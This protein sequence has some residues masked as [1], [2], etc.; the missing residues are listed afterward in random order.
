MLACKPTASTDASAQTCMGLTACVGA[1]LARKFYDMRRTFNHAGLTIRSQIRYT[2]YFE[3][4]LRRLVTQPQTVTITQSTAPAIEIH[5]VRLNTI[6][7]FDLDGGCDPIVRVL[8][9]AEDDHQPIVVFGTDTIGVKHVSPSSKVF[10]LSL[11]AVRVAGDFALHLFDRDLLREEKMGTLWLHSLFL[12]APLLD[13]VCGVYR[14]LS[15]EECERESLPQNTSSLTFSKAH[16][17]GAA[18]D[19]RDAKFDPDFHLEIFFTSPPNLRGCGPNLSQER[20]SSAQD[21]AGAMLLERARDKYQRAV[22]QAP[23]SAAVLSFEEWVVKHWTGSDFGEYGHGMRLNRQ[24]SLVSVQSS[25]TK[26]SRKK[27]ILTKTMSTR[28]TASRTT[29]NGFFSSF[30]SRATREHHSPSGLRTRPESSPIGRY[31]AASSSTRKLSSHTSNEAAGPRPAVA[32]RASHPRVRTDILPRASSPGLRSESDLWSIDDADNDHA[33]AA[34]NTSNM[35]DNMDNANAKDNRNNNNMDKNNNNKGYDME[36]PKSAAPHEPTRQRGYSN[37]DDDDDDEDVSQE[38]RAREGRSRGR[39]VEATEEDEEEEDGWESGPSSEEDGPHWHKPLKPGPDRG[40]SGPDLGQRPDRDPRAGTDLGV[41][42]ARSYASS[43]DPWLLGQD[44]H[45]TLS[46]NVSSAPPEPRPDE[47]FRRALE[48]DLA[49][50]LGISISCVSCDK[51]ARSQAGYLEAAIAFFDDSLPHP[52]PD[53][54]YHHTSP[55]LRIGAMV[56]G[57]VEQACDPQSVLR[58][59][60]TSRYVETVQLSDT[61]T[62][63]LFE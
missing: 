41:Q 37:D 5:R 54:S 10:D 15:A 20:R 22:L 63:A 62:A 36:R 49:T 52:D 21:A 17:D 24:G 57:L 13:E 42:S 50:A 2:R 33:A 8:V 58:S 56:E 3:E 53:D 55:L 30:A 44:T 48:K 34:A 45:C 25:G 16:I 27:G 60:S 47:V 23:A 26:A 18:K 51:V 40:R 35:N 4:V 28:T 9:R 6:P 31:A 59:Q 14:S 1:E 12:H 11:P 38:G 39:H 29:Q 7:H 46:L 32:D 61:L 43:V 19:L